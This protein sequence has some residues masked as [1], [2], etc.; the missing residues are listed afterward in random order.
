MKPSRAVLDVLPDKGL[1]HEY[2]VKTSIRH[3]KYLRPQLKGGND[4]I[5]A[6]FAAKILSLNLEHFSSFEYFL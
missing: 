4:S 5:S 6:K 2:L 3:N 1:T